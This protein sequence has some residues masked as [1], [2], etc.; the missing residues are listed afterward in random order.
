MTKLVKIFCRGF[1]CEIIELDIDRLKDNYLGMAL[2]IPRL[3]RLAQHRSKV[4]LG[5]C[6]AGPQMNLI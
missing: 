2:E 4:N 3:L 5:N 6:R 1:E